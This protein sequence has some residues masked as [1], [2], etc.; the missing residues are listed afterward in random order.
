MADASFAR[1]AAIGTRRAGD[2][3]SPWKC[4]GQDK[5]PSCQHRLRAGRTDSSRVLVE[6]RRRS[7]RDA[8]QVVQL[9]LKLDDDLGL[10][11]PVLQ[12]GVLPLELRDLLPIVRGA[13]RRRPT[14]LGIERLLA[15]FRANAAPLAQ[16]RRIQPLAAEKITDGAGLA[17][18][19]IGF[20]QD[21]RLVLGGEHPT[22]RAFE[23]LVRI[24]GMTRGAASGRL[25]VLS[26]D[27]ALVLVIGVV[28]AGIG[29][30]VQRKVT[31]P[32][33]RII[34]IVV[35]ALMG[36]GLTRDDI[37]SNIIPRLDALVP[38]PHAKRS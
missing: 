26:V 16:V 32:R 27:A 6:A 38:E 30:L 2:R 4:S 23:G 35:H 20:A 5:R 14:A 13:R 28:S 25:Q 3:S 37:E 36:M 12:P 19:R 15:A 10:P 11:Q 1:G 31:A 29:Q 22:A 7:D 18:Q 34:E 24:R 33:Q 17:S 21:P 8:Q 9:F